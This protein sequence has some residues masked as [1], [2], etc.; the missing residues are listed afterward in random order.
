[1]SIKPWVNVGDPDKLAIRCRIELN[2]GWLDINDGERYKLES[3]SLSDS[4]VTWRKKELQSQYLPGT[5]VLSAVK[6]NIVENVTV[7]VIGEDHY[8]MTSA[9]RKL[10]DAFDQLYYSMWWKIDTDEFAWHCQLADYQI[11]ADRDLRHAS[12]CK[13]VARVPRYPEVEHTPGRMF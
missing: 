7:W 11:T 3:S 9:V 6:D 12:M 10:T 2:K 4:A 1:M 13:V 8:A 5:W